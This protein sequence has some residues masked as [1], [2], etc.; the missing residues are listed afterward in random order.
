MQSDT[1]VGS[2]A[3]VFSEK[4]AIITPTHGEKILQIQLSKVILSR[5]GSRI[6]LRVPQN[7]TKKT[8]H[9]NDIICRKIMDSAKSKILQ[10]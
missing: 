7:F 5:G 10:F 3:A 9:T 6:N 1:T 2:I 4:A 8:D